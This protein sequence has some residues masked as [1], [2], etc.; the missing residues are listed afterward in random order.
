[1]NAHGLH[2]EI[3]ETADELRGQYGRSGYPD[4]GAVLMSDDDHTD[5]AAMIADMREAGC[6]LPVVAFTADVPKP[7]RIVSALRAGA[8]DYLCFPED[9]AI[10][11][12][13]VEAVIEHAAS[14]ARH[15]EMTALAKTRIARLSRQE[16]RVLESVIAG[17]TSKETARQMGL[18]NRTVEVHRAAVLAKLEVATSAGAIAMGIAAGI[19]ATIDDRAPKE[20]DEAVRS[21]LAVRR[22]GTGSS[23]IP[24][25]G[26]MMAA[27]PE[28]YRQAS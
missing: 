5:L 4:Q 16:R 7:R 10:V 23:L 26:R 17:A 2:T 19:M 1:M 15:Y 12:S 24:P 13:T 9:L 21:T 20:P 22:I 14:L 6:F 3:Y 11:G 27:G 8:V 18:S 25:P 28:L